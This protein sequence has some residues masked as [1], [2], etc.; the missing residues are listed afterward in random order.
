[1][2]VNV[3][4]GFEADGFLHTFALSKPRLSEQRAECNSSYF[5][6]KRFRAKLKRQKLSINNLNSKRYEENVFRPRGN[7][8][9]DNEC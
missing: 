5:E 9:D 4:G 2:G 8:D 3:E 1:M 7:G 6:R